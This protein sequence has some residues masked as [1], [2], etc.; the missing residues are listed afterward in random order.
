MSSPTTREAADCALESFIHAEIV[1]E[2]DPEHL[3]T[4]KAGLERVL[5]D[6]RAAVEDWRPWSSGRAR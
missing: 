2:T 6:V 1:R 5:G 4:V 3:A